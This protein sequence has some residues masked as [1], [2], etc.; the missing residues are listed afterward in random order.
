MNIQVGIILLYRLCRY[1]FNRTIIYLFLYLK[2][3]SLYVIAKIIKKNDFSSDLVVIFKRL[4]IITDTIL[5]KIIV[6]NEIK[7]MPLNFGDS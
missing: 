3:Y 7:Q 2:E 1:L 6:I 5:K 4:I